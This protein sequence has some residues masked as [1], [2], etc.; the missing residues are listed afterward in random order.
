VGDDA[1]EKQADEFDL[2]FLGDNTIGNSRRQDILPVHKE[3]CRPT[4]VHEMFLGKG[5]HTYS[6]NESL[7]LHPVEPLSLRVDWQAIMRSPRDATVEEYSPFLDVSDFKNHLSS[8][9]RE[10]ESGSWRAGYLLFNGAVHKGYPSEYSPLA[11]YALDEG[12]ISFKED[13]N[14]RGYDPHMSRLGASQTGPREPTSRWE[15]ALGVGG[16]LGQSIEKTKDERLWDWGASKLINIQILNSVAFKE[17]TGISPVTPISFREYVAAKIPFYSFLS[18]SEGSVMGDQATTFKSIGQ[19]DRSAVIQIGI[20]VDRSGKPVGCANCENN[21]CDSMYVFFLRT[22][23]H[24]TWHY[25]LSFV[26]CDDAN[27]LS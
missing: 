7:V 13:R 19:L 24:P 16:S 25:R 6:T 5:G 2:G 8:I 14:A 9:K 10:S 4:F 20:R 18:V 15:M 22:H 23:I 12:V 17:F 26:S 3:K 21:I 27:Q 11:E 1:G